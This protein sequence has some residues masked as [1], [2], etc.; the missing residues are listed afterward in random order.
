VKLKV[1]LVTALI[2]P[3]SFLIVVTTLLRTNK[4]AMWGIE[5]LPAVTPAT[6]SFGDLANITAT[7]DCI[8]AQVPI[9]GCDPYGRP[10]QPY[11]ELPAR[12]LNFL[13]IGTN[14]N[15][16]LGIALAA[17]FFL[18]ITA[19]AIAIAIN[20]QKSLFT[21]IA[22]Q[23]L[24]ALIAISPASMLAV[25]R[26]QIEQLTLALVVLALITLS[27][28]PKSRFTRAK[29]LGSL[30][31]FLATATKYLSIGMFLPFIHRNMLAKRNNAALLG[32]AL[33]A[34]F[35][36]ISLPSV[37]Q[38]AETSGAS[39]PQT[40]KSAFA[41]TTLLATAFSGENISYW[42]TNEVLNNWQTV[43][44]ASYALFIACTII[45]IAIL[46]IN[47][48]R[49]TAAECTQLPWVLTLGSSG[50][51]LFPYLLGNSHDYRLIF[52]IPTAAG[53]VL[54]TKSYP[55]LGTT[56]AV[57]AGIAAVTSAAML[58]TPGGFIWAT[59]ALVIGDAALMVLLSGIAAMWL[60]TAFKPTKK[61]GAA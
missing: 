8:A 34:I 20:W 55:A 12:L 17:I 4:W 30:S 28:A 40:T 44:I 52:L 54:L 21:L 50:V 41:V 61:V 38:A 29:Y 39:E 15:Q 14:N 32:I 2:A 48:N 27:I 36:T 23:S 16:A 7:A 56:L 53:A 59:P 45:W 5:A 3:I 13:G 42:P 57:C 33:S 6:V 37:F 10:F 31:S 26:G 25:E 18:T 58:P 24:V 47:R 49:N 46:A 1:N 60:T 19:L 51:L 43:K 9:E 22:S 35:I 11:V